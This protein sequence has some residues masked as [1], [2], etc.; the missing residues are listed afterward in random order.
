MRY[1]DLREDLPQG[2]VVRLGVD[3]L[4]DAG[5]SMSVDRDREPAGGVPVGA[6]LLGDPL[7]LAP[8]DGLDGLEP[9]GDGPL[10]P[11]GPVAPAVV[12]GL[13]VEPRLPSGRACLPALV[14]ELLEFGSTSGELVLDVDLV[15][16]QQPADAVHDLGGQQRLPG[17]RGV[18]AG[19]EVV[20]DDLP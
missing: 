13:P 4:P 2:L 12:L 17:A 9:V 7:G 15:G 1:P 5:L 19:M 18:L 10:D 8:G 3:A 16:S 14:A 20:V 11:K 6:A